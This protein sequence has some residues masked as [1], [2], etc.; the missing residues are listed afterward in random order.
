MSNNNSTTP[1]MRMSTL[2]LVD[3]IRELE[4]RAAN[5][6]REVQHRLLGEHLKLEGQ[7]TTRLG[8]MNSHTV[9]ELLQDFEMHDEGTKLV[10]GWAIGPDNKYCAHV[11]LES[12]ERGLH[13]YFNW[14]GHT[15][16]HRQAVLPK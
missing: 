8:E 4:Q 3:E 7:P 9:H 5:L 2:E 16:D 13:D 10:R 11:W 12:P 15:T 1:T 14:E 6:K